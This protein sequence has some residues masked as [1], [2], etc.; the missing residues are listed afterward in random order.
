MGGR[1]AAIQFN[2]QNGS[3]ADDSVQDFPARF[4]MKHDHLYSATENEFIRLYRTSDIEHA[5]SVDDNGYTYAYAHGG[6]GSVNLMETRAEHRLPKGEKLSLIH[7][8]PGKENSPLSDADIESSIKR[9]YKTVTAIGTR[10]TYRADISNASKRNAKYAAESYKK[11]VDG[12]LFKNRSQMHNVFLHW[13]ET[14]GK[15]YGVVLSF[16]KTRR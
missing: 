13:N 1:G 8:H 4:N 11:I 3:G 6:K 12:V 14:E 15:K 7:N 10:W 16:E 2:S 5:I 9:G